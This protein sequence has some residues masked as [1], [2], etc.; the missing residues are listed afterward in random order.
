MKE[1]KLHGNSIIIGKDALDKIKEL[2]IKR[3]FIVTGGS[4]MFRNGA[5]DRL[6][7]LLESCGAQY[8]IFKDVKK[9]PSINT[10]IAA[11]EI[12]KEY[13]PDVVIGIGGG[14]P[15]DVAK[16]AAVFYDYPEL[17]IKNPDSLTLPFKRR[18]TIL[19]AIPSTSG[20]GT[21]VTR[22]SVLTY[23]DMNLK[24][25]LKCDAFIP[26]VAILDAALT[27]SMPKN[28]VAET[29][30][31]ALTHAVECYINKNIDEYSEVLAEG[32]V[33]GLFKFL[34]L[35]FEKGDYESREKVHIYSAMA[36]SAFSNVGLGMAHGISHAFGGKFGYAHGLLNAIALPYVLKFNSMDEE[37]NNRLNRLAKI[38][39]VPDF[40][41]AVIE[42][43][44]K[45][46]IP[47]SFKDMGLSDEDF[48][49]NFEELLENSMKGSTRVNPV[50]ITKAQM[51]QLL[52]NIFKGIV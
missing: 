52:L 39:D 1:L 25:G 33:K 51:E 44:K 24:I 35:S 16:A 13:S 37:V 8:Q 30:M 6:T 27:L 41:E 3:A 23:D 14:S 12:M 28:I 20:T 45:L 38:I 29:G 22:A 2:K 19:I 26:D 47:L 18:K 4:A 43:N 42:L 46:N 32:A 21:E 17:D 5:I 40:I 31:D 10:V 15:I 11:V 36:G 48:N 50:K 34:P 7:N 9:N 49:N